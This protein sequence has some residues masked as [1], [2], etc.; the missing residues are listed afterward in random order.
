MWSGAGT[1][2]WRRVRCE[3]GTAKYSLRA[4]LCL[5]LIAGTA[6]MPIVEATSAKAN[7]L[8]MSSDN[9]ETGWYPN[10]PQL[11]P[12]SVTGGNFGEI[13][14]TQL[15][16]PVNAQPIVSQ[17]TVL[18]VTETNHAYGLNSTTGT[19]QWQDSFGTPEQP[20]Q[21]LNCGDV[22]TNLGITGTPVVD[23]STN[24][25]YFVAAN[26]EAGNTGQ[27]FMEAVNVATGAT[28]SN[29]PAGGVPIQGAADGDPS[30]VF[31]AKYQTQRAG[32]VLVNGVV[33]AAFG[34]QCDFGN[35]NGW[36][37]GVST[38][39]A[40]ITTMWASE[41]NTTIT[42]PFQ[43]GAGIWQAS[44]APVVDANGDIFVSTGNGFIPSGPEPG[45]D[46]ANQKF[47]E[48]VVELHT[49]S[50][51]KLA[52]VDW[53]MAA[54][55]LQLNNQDG[56]LGSGG[57]IALPASMGT[58]DDPDPMV[59]D[60]KQGILYVLN[61]NN[62]G[63]YQQGP[64][65][66]DNVESETGPNG[67]VWDRAGV[68]PGDGGYI[69]VPTAGSTS[70]SQFGGG[71]SLNV[72][73]RTDTNGVLSFPL[74]GTTTNSG[75]AFAFGS[76]API[77]TSNGTASGSALLWIIHATGTGGANSQLEAFNP[78]PVNPG[79]NGTLEQVWS[80]GIFTS[81]TFSQ[82]AVDNGKLYVGTK[83]SSLLGFGTLP[84]STPAV[85][86]T[87]LSFAP[88]VVAQSTTMTETF[89]A[90]AP[91]TVSSF[92][93]AGGAYSIGTPTPS[94]P[95][96]L[97]SGQSISVPV[98]FTPTAFGANSG[99]LTANVTGNTASVTLSGDGD[100]TNPSLSWS[101]DAVTFDPQPINGSPVTM[102]V[103]VT[104]LST[105][106]I[107]LSSF[108]S[109]AAPFVVTNPPT[110]P[111]ALAPAGQA[112]DSFTFTVQF[113][114]PGSS[115]NFDHQFNSIATMRT[116][117]GN[118]GIAITGSADPP[119]Q[120]T[121][122]P[123]ALNFGNVAV[124]SSATLSF[125]LGDQGG[126][127]LTII[128]ST[129]PTTNGFS[130]LTDPFVQLANT[131]PPDEIAPATSIQET[132]QF[133]P[134]TNGPV[135]G[136][137]LIEGNDGN[138]VQTITLT[139]TGF[140]SATTTTTSTST[141][142]TSTTTTTIP[143]T[144]TTSTTTTTTTIPTTTTTHP[145]TTT[146]APTTTTTAG[147]PPPPPPPPPPPA[148]T[149]TS[150]ST[151]TTSTTTTTTTIPTTTT[152][153]API[154]T[155]S[156]RAGTVG[157]SLTLRTTGDPG[158]G[159]LSFRVRAGGTSKCT[160]KGAVLQAKR[161]GTCFVTAT[162]SARKG[163][164]SVTSSSTTITFTKPS[165]RT[166]VVASVVPFSASN[167]SLN[168]SAKTALDA[169]AK[170]LASGNSV[171]VTGYAHGNVAQAKR[172]AK[173]VANYLITRVKVH[174]SLKTVTVTALHEV[175]LKRE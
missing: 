152:T 108:V 56:D 11:T 130:A 158:G 46:L 112:G 128:S 90:S 102:P 149:T 83:D 129:P 6:A 101:P 34:S 138:G 172:R 54:D 114:P 20:I 96:S 71:G 143:A 131:T 137:W 60:G 113:S 98:T 121:T 147:S 118:F 89:T 65:S 3:I 8:Q 79:A 174:I 48:S 134:T 92:S 115:G 146:T 52:P 27:D 144:T 123:A 51:G 110:T 69:Y 32:L 62:L 25:A 107:T 70:F 167:D 170:K 155:L 171:V 139:G 19:I 9:S 66:T 35:W 93:V 169:F 76:G 67:G 38:A 50:S 173:E 26:E 104:N 84:S 77:V 53:F 154:L 162:K 153:R 133:A 42:G 80:S 168:A 95:K 161:P 10:E 156:T 116:N 140:T 109:P 39:T 163:T 45:T 94:L 135:T 29:W 41:E 28:P 14:D 17:P 132:V 43:P 151:T 55:A 166:P 97:T 57:P 86:G 75:N 36:L 122:I 44:S 31:N 126:I 37:V 160:L 82:P 58:T 148:S 4:L 16:G 15:N 47:A 157:S 87:N 150:T 165:P 91:T 142:T 30:S 127:P 85:A 64:G 141:T 68:W 59:I 175:S 106:T 21:N 159:S 74:V 13:F 99:T 1:D 136:S 164:P 145:T 40:S 7:T 12:A 124:G 88:T 2:V 119:A 120:I 33:Y 103:T 73:Q 72:F 78:V 105:S 23:P 5:L 22:G 18:A 117:L 49:N 100:S 63:G 24:I 125:Q 61:M 81:T 111:M